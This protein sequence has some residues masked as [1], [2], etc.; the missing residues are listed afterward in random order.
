ME[1]LKERQRAGYVLI[2][3]FANAYLGLGDNDEALT[4]FERA[5]QEQSNVLKSTSSVSPA[6]R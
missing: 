3:A 6:L 4:W 2:A 5:S 1:E